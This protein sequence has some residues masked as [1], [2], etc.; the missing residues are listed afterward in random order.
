M[1]PFHLWKD[2]MGYR[3]PLCFITLAYALGIGAAYVFSINIVVLLIAGA[4]ALAAFT[5]CIVFRTRGRGR[6]GAGRGFVIRHMFVWA[7]LF[8]FAAGGIYCSRELARDDALAVY[9]VTRYNN[10]FGGAAV[11]G[12]G[13]GGG[14]GADAG[15]G[16][17]GSAGAE[18]GGGAGAASMPV[19]RGRVLKVREKGDDYRSLT[20]ASGGRNV[21]VNVS[22][23]G[24][25]ASDV[26]GRE[27]CF[28]GK[29]ELPPGRRNPGTFDYALYLKTENVRAIVKCKVSDVEVSCQASRR[30]PLWDAYA[31]LCKLK[32]A[33][34]ER[35]AALMP[36]SE[37]KL[38]AG[39][40]FGGSAHM[41]EDSY[42]LFRRN[43]IAHILS[44]SGLHVAIVYAFFTM[45]AGRR[46][47]LLV[48][49]LIIVA[50]ICY[51]AMSEFS[52]PVV[53]AVTMIGLHIASRISGRRYDFLTGISAA[54]LIMLA[55]NPLDLFSAGFQLSFLAVLLLA[56]AMPFTERYFGYRDRRT[57]A[58][59]SCTELERR[60]EYSTGKMIKE[61]CAGALLPLIV[62]QLGMAPLVAYHF[63]NISLTGLILNP[64][65]VAVCGWMIPLGVGMLLLF[66]PLSAFPPLSLF[67]DIGAHAEALM[68]GLIIKL[69]NIADALP[70]GHFTVIS[71][72]LPLVLTFYGLLFFLLSEYRALLFARQRFRRALI[73]AAGIA[74]AACLAF[75][76]PLCVRDD[77]ALIFVD[78][79]QGD[80]LHIRTPDGKN[81]LVDGGGSVDYD[82][83]KKT[84]LPYLLKNGVGRLDG[85]FATHLHTDHWRGLAE[86]SRYIDVGRVYVYEG[87]RVR[88]NEIA[89]G[90]TDE[91]EVGA[92][93]TGEGVFE[94]PAQDGYGAGTGIVKI[95]AGKGGMCY[96][97]QGDSVNLDKN[98]NLKVLYPP[99]REI[100]EYLADAAAELDGSGDENRNSL[101]MRVDYEGVSVLMTGDA[102]E[103]AER[104]LLGIYDAANPALDSR[105]LKIGHHG[106][107]YSTTKE[108]L[109]AVN[110][111]AAVIQVGRNNFGHPTRE[112][113]DKLAGNDIIVFRNDTSGAIMF[114][115]SDGKVVNAETC[116]ERFQ[117]N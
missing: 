59:L 33:Y 22:G 20:V 70:G 55:V 32:Y 72:P 111:D 47:S 37:Y 10:V 19:L 6:D 54:A 102:G 23:K 39:M 116:A 42:E 7:L 82:V 14:V 94:N 74:T 38:F 44:V 114:K 15:S 68:S 107:K 69:T 8:V 62:I 16:A 2:L 50:L 81:Y 12:G 90:Q 76:S 43:G 109:T 3:R 18:A 99:R 105:I 98:V 31:A 24:M 48:Y 4:I 71:P 17:G 87:N 91:E 11:G 53:R 58:A 100:D 9:A 108:F 57:G 51:A 64:P 63:N 30:A 56:F 92:K 67:F 75:A 106:S 52:P 85:V 73:T 29:V 104:A 89:A 95:R 83:G 65:V 21:L 103:E 101:I 112:V 66:I 41:D 88:E 117:S 84:L 40:M 35:C 49:A 45:L 113:L 27:V 46:R 115:I 97:A 93:E 5:G 1:W 60:A 13:A 36:E 77:S 78:V 79:G 34:L 61:K 26:V 96:I 28:S 110:P 25:A 80:C 86:L